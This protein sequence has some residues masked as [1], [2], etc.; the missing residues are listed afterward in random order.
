MK[1]YYIQQDKYIYFKGFDPITK[2]V[3]WTSTLDR[4]AMWIDFDVA[5]DQ[6]FYLNVWDEDDREWKVCSIE[7]G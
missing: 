6:A 3:K 2:D 4:A 1:L 7:A 5:E